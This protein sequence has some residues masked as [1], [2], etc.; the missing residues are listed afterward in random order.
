M[1]DDVISIKLK[2]VSNP[3]IFFVKYNIKQ[4]KDKHKLK[5]V[6][7]AMKVLGFCWAEMD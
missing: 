5:S 7:D 4:F 3:Y 2:K 6:S 1:K